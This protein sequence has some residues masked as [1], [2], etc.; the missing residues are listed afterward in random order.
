MTRAGQEVTVLPEKI[1]VTQEEKGRCVRLQH[2]VTDLKVCLNA[3]M[4]VGV[5]LLRNLLK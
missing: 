3:L 1:L 2:C 4:P 5:N